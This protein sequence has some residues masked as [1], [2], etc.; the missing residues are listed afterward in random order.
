M[1]SGKAEKRKREAEKRAYPNRV[2]AASARS[3][4]AR[5]AHPPRRL[6]LQVA[7]G[8]TN[9]RAR[10]GERKKEGECERTQWA[11]AAQGEACGCGAPPQYIYC[12]GCGASCC[13]SCLDACSDKL[14]EDLALPGRRHLRVRPHG[15]WDAFRGHAWRRDAPEFAALR[16]C[17]ATADGCV[18]HWDTECP[19]CVRQSLDTLEE[20]APEVE[21]EVEPAML[22]SLSSLS[23]SP[24]SLSSLFFFHLLLPHCKNAAEFCESV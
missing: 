7:C 17:D 12:K 18:G 9:I 23:L 6:R 3:R 16:R 21:V 20:E 11:F 14:E 1:A 13:C 8:L 2:R 10:R 19:C 4:P 24:L 15:V 5:Q 22:L